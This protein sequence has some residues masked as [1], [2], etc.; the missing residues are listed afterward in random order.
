MLVSLVTVFEIEITFI[1]KWDAKS[2]ILMYV[3]MQVPTEE[4]LYK[5]EAYIIK[6][7]NDCG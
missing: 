4:A 1:F 7:L 5:A 6:G 3:D 2:N